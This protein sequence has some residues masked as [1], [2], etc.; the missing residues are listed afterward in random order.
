[1]DK[2]TKK[3]IHGEGTGQQGSTSALPKAPPLNAPG[4]PTVTPTATPT[5]LS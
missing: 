1:M 2:V 5:W 4:I 3:Q